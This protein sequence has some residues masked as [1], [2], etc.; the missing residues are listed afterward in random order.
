[1]R[2][3]L[4][5]QAP[6][7]ASS[8]RSVSVYVGPAFRYLS[9]GLSVVLFSYDYLLPTYVTSGAPVAARGVDAQ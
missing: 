2:K 8:D 4:E 9:L 7:R 5:A 3:I 6:P 1:M